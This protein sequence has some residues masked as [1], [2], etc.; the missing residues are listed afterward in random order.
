MWNLLKELFGAKKTPVIPRT[1]FFD[2]EDNLVDYLTNQAVECLKE[3]VASYQLLREKAYKILSILISGSAASILLF[4]NAA[5]SGEIAKINWGFLICF[6]GWSV[7]SII[8]TYGCIKSFGRETIYAS[9]DTLYFTIEDGS[10][11]TL[12]EIKRLRLQEYCENNWNMGETQ[13]VMHILLNIAITGA[14]ISVIASAGV[15]SYFLF[16]SL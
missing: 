3:R 11:T 15:S 13:R 9:P 8:L 12:A 10:K 5:K 14:V 4:I 1:Y 7:C 16:S 6:V 2:A